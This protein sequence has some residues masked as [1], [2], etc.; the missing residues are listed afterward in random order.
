M[1]GLERLSMDAEEF[2]TW[3]K[4]RDYCESAYDGRIQMECNAIKNSLLTLEDAKRR[5]RFVDR[6]F[7]HLEEDDAWCRSE[8]KRIRKQIDNMKA[9]VGYTG[10]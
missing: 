4:K 6:Q 2:F 5:R 8:V 9:K 7:E 10:I 1:W 3:L